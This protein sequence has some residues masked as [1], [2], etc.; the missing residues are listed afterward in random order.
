MDARNSATETLPLAETPQFFEW[1]FPG[2][3]TRILLQLDLVPQILECLG[4]C[5]QD[6]GGIL[7]GTVQPNGAVITGFE[8]FASESGKSFLRTACTDKERFAKA[9]ERCNRSR[10]QSKVLGYFRSQR[11]GEMSLGSE[12]I[13]LIKEFFQD[14]ASVF[15][16]VQPRGDEGPISASFFF[17]NQ[18]EIC[19]KAFMPFPFDERALVS[20]AMAELARLQFDHNASPVGKPIA[21]RRVWTPIAT[22][23]LGVAI[24]ASMLFVAFRGV[25]TQQP[26]GSSQTPLALSVKLSRTEMTV[27]WDAQSA[28]VKNARSGVITIADGSRKQ[29]VLL[30]TTLLHGG[31]LVYE[32]I[33]EKVHLTLE[34]FAPNGESTRE[35]LLALLSHVKHVPASNEKPQLREPVVAVNQSFP[36]PSTTQ[37]STSEPLRSM[38]APVTERRAAPRFEFPR[39]PAP[40]NAP[41]LVSPEPIALETSANRQAP[42]PLVAQTYLPP[43]PTAE[44]SLPKAAPPPMEQT[45][46][47]TPVQS[48][49][50]QPLIPPKPI[51]QVRPSLS[52]NLRALVSREVLVQI[53]V[54]VDATGKVTRTEPVTTRSAVAEYLQSAAANAARQWS[55]EPARSNGKP[56]PSELVLQ[57]RFLPEK[58]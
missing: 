5:E 20:E 46:P 31:K 56:A 11:F 42:P 7:M 53:R 58:R 47:Q 43:P 18:G 45:A 21:P 49:S 25:M 10:I 37:T 6:G 30:T 8:P 3:P 32:P 34:V 28:P 4:A 1:S 39:K 12:D 9:I 35:V 17:W 14:P 2:S 54:S 40:D 44:P 36:K 22:W 24:M 19:E 52:A 41:A 27:F 26:S 23:G 57:F 13:L 29:E 33:G 51:Q 50:S 16:L 55:F 48:S 15:L 38:D